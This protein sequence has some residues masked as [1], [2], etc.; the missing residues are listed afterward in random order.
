MHVP[1]PA[2]SCVK[3]V[4]IVKGKYELAANMRARRA[5]VELA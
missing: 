5:K 1:V 2:G 3:V 4:K